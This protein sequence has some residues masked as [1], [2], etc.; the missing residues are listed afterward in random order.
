MNQAEVEAQRKRRRRR[1]RRAFVDHWEDVTG[2]SMVVCGAND[3]WNK[4]VLAKT[5]K[6]SRTTRDA[7]LRFLERHGQPER[8]GGKLKAELGEMV[9]N[10]VFPVG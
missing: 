1:A 4:E 10:T 7:M 5:M 9:V 2:H 6:K 8:D 3:A